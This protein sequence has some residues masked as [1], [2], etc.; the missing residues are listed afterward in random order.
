MVRGG[1]YQHVP[2]SHPTASKVT[3]FKA[4]K[5]RPGAAQAKVPSKFTHSVPSG[6]KVPPGQADCRHR[7]P[8]GHDGSWESRGEMFTST[9]IGLKMRGRANV[10]VTCSRI[11]AIPA[12]LGRRTRGDIVADIVHFGRL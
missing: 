10:E 2:P 5:N 7:K 6:Q 9:P 12:T 3:G 1:T 8:S 4:Q 11:A